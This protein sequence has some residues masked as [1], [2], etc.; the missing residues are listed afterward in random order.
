MHLLLIIEI[1]VDNCILFFNHFIISLLCLLFLFLWSDGLLFFLNSL[2]P[3]LW[4]LVSP[5][6]PLWLALVSLIR[7]ASLLAE[8]CSDEGMSFTLETS[9][10]WMSEKVISTMLRSLSVLSRDLF[11]SLLLLSWRW[12]CF[13]RWFFV[14]RLAWLRVVM[15]L[16]MRLVWAWWFVASCSW[17]C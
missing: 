3:H 17:V 4:S 14:V 1:T 8:A 16:V 13:S 9:S 2:F 6:V 7:L 10:H 12:W 5:S 11:H 15:V